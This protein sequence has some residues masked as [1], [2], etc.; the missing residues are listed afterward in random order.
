MDHSQP[1]EIRIKI[2]KHWVAIIGETLELPSCLLGNVKQIGNSVEGYRRVLTASAD[3]CS[4]G[5]YLKSTLMS[6][7]PECCSQ[8]VYHLSSITF[9]V[10]H[11]L[12]M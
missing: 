12:R 6:C 2:E 9:D 8:Q 3:A 4:E 1:F 7:S 5:M 10:A 11:C